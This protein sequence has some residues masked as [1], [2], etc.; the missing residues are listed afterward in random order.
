MDNAEN[1]YL[2][3]FIVN[4]SMKSQLIDLPKILYM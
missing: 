3:I 4:K 2:F 1:I